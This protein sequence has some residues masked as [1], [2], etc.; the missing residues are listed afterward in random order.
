MPR[1]LNIA[2]QLTALG[3]AAVLRLTAP[4]W[5]LIIFVVSLIGPAIALAPLSFALRQ[6]PDRLRAPVAIP[7][8]GTAAC[9]VA[10]AACVPETDDQRDF[11]P[12]LELVRPGNG[13]HHPAAEALSTVGWVAVLGVF[14]G[15]V[16]IAAA[17]GRARTARTR[18]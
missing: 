3:L 10:A 7:F 6:G 14:V 18:R 13:L 1:T 2:V 12:L 17:L 11:V 16:W 8:V 5:L 4:G 15:V 9:L